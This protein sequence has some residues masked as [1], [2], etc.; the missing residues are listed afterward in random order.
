ML[1]TADKSGKIGLF[2]K[3]IIPFEIFFVLGAGEYV[4]RLEG[5][6]RKCF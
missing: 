1:E 5:K 2:T 3:F 6:I 4:E